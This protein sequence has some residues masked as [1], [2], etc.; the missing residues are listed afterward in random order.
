MEILEFEKYE[1]HKAAYFEILSFLESRMANTYSFPS[2]MKSYK[3]LFSKNSHS[4]VSYKSDLEPE[5]SENICEMNAIINRLKQE[6][7][8]LDDISKIS[9]IIKLSA[10]RTTREKYI[11]LAGDLRINQSPLNINLLQIKHCIAFCKVFL[12]EIA[13]FSGIESRVNDVEISMDTYV[14]TSLRLINELND[15]DDGDDGDDE[16]DKLKIIMPRVLGRSLSVYGII[17][18]H[19]LQESF[20]ELVNVV[21]GVL[22]YAHVGNIKHYISKLDEL[23]KLSKDTISNLLSNNNY[24]PLLS[25]DEKKLLKSI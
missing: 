8:N 3:N 21:K 4:K 2:M 17:N 24:A 11:G 7:L 6:K 5:I 9:K 18:E 19:S 13:D 1:K 22:V 16:D 12:N 10:S 15:R 23:E 14:K 20:Q 25:D